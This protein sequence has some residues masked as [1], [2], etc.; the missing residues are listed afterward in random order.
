MLIAENQTVSYN[1]LQENNSFFELN[2]DSGSE[3]E[4]IALKKSGFIIFFAEGVHEK[5]LFEL[6]PASVIMKYNTPIPMT[7]YL[8]KE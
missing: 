7:N 1:N 8:R 6:Y 4:I 2:S 5:D 3:V